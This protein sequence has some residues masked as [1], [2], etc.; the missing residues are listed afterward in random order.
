MHTSDSLHQAES[1]QVPVIFMVFNRP[2]T[3]QRVFDTIAAAR[4][5]KLLLIADGPRQN[6]E[7]E[8]EACGQVRH[9]VSCVDWPCEVF[10][11]FSEINLGCSERVISGLNWAFSL[12]EEAIILEDDCLPSSSFFPFCRELLERF[13]DDSRIAYISG[14]NLIEEHVKTSASYFFSRIGGIWGWATWRSKWERYDQHLKDW[15]QLKSEGMI[16]E[17]FDEPLATKYLTSIFDAMHQKRGPDTWDYQWLYTCLKNNSLIAVSSVNLVTNIGF[18]DGATHTLEKDNRFVRSAT[19]LKL[20]LKHPFGFIPLRT[21]DRRRI[22]LFSRP[23]FVRVLN[24]VRRLAN[25]T[26]RRPS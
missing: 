13:R 19:T 25:G 21:A 4:P 24:K 9:I 3:T 7:G 11:N 8:A 5:A 22:R 1:L 6:K 20:P 2:D 14:E 26:R 16:E 18:G 17:I 12:V 15:P 23:I 10:K